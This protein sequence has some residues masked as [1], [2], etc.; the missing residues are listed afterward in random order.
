MRELGSL[1][2]TGTPNRTL[3]LTPTLALNLALTLTITLAL[4][5]NPDP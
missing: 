1:D 3:I 5:Y 2:G 4:P